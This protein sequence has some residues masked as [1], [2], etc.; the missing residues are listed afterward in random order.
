MY[1][2]QQKWNDDY[3]IVFMTQLGYLVRVSHGAIEPEGDDWVLQFV[4]NSG[5]FY[6]NDLTAMLDN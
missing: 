5:K 6:C 2:R 3:R 4:K 1:A